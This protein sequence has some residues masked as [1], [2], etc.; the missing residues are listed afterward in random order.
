MLSKSIVHFH[1]ILFINILL[2]QHHLLVLSDPEVKISFL[3][4]VVKTK[5]ISST[6]ISKTDKNEKKGDANFIRTQTEY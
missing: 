4:N 2:M 6:V 1:L 5:L 3:K